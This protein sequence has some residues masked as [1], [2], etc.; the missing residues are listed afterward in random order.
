MAG[1]PRTT[2]V[3]IA[4]ATSCQVAQAFSSSR[5]GKSV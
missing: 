5:V 2:S 3:L 1:A 4:S